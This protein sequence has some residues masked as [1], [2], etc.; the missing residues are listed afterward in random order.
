VPSNQAEIAL[1]MLTPSEPPE[2]DETES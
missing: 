2:L 1:Q